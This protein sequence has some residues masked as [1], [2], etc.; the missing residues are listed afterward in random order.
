VRDDDICVL[1][2]RFTD[3]PLSPG[4]RF[5]RLREELGDGFIGVEIDSSRGNEHGH[6]MMAHSVLT[7]ALRDEPGE[8]THDA[9]NQVLDFFRERLIPV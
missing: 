2:V 3:D 9:L 1:G 4:D 5:A 8:P 7:E 6:S